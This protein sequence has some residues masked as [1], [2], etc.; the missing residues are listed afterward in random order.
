MRIWFV[1]VILLAVQGVYAFDLV[2][3]TADPSTPTSDGVLTGAYADFTAVF[4][5]E[6]D[7]DRVEFVFLTR[8]GPAVRAA[9]ICDDDS[10]TVGPV[11]L[12]L[13]GAEG[14]FIRTRAPSARSWFDDRIT[15]RVKTHG[16]QVS[17]LEVT[18]GPSSSIRFEAEDDSGSGSYRLVRDGVTIASDDVLSDTVELADPI[19]PGDEVR[20]ALV[21]TDAFGTVHTE[22]FGG[23]VPEEPPTI[24]S[25]SNR[26]YLDD[27]D[28]GLVGF[29]VSGSVEHVR[30]IVDGRE[31]PARC[32][33]GSCVAMI[34]RP[35]ASESV[36]VRV[37]DSF[38][39]TASRTATVSFVA[40]TVAPIFDR[41]TTR[42]ASYDGVTG[43]TDGEVFVDFIENAMMRPED[44][45]VS[46]DGRRTTARSCERVGSL[47]RCAVPMTGSGRIEFRSA[48]DAAGNDAT[49]PSEALTERRIE[50][51]SRAPRVLQLAVISGA[52]SSQADTVE[53][54]SAGDIVIAVQVVAEGSRASRA[55]VEVSD[56]SGTRIEELDL[57]CEMLAGSDARCTSDPL[58]ID[59]TSRLNIEI[60]DASGSPFRAQRL[61][62]V[63]GTS[64]PGVSRWSVIDVKEIPGYY[65]PG[66]LMPI[67][68][69]ARIG[70]PVLSGGMS[71]AGV[72]LVSCRGIE[73]GFASADGRTV[74]ITGFSDASAL[75]GGVGSCTVAVTTIR[76]GM[77]DPEPEEVDLE[78]RLAPIASAGI[79]DPASLYEKSGS[80]AKL[81]SALSW[82]ETAFGYAS[83]ACDAYE[84][85]NLVSLSVNLAAVATGGDVGATPMG[86]LLAQAGGALFRGVEGIGVVA[87]P[88]CAVANCQIPID[89]DGT[90]LQD[91]VLGVYED[92]EGGARSSI[93]DVFNDTLGYDVVGSASSVS[94]VEDSL[95]LSAITACV[96]GVI[97][98][99]R[100][101]TQATCARDLCLLRV[102]TGDYAGTAS[103]CS[104]SY[105]MQVCAFVGDEII[106]VV[107]WVSIFTDISDQIGGIIRQPL[108]IVADIGLEMLISAVTDLSPSAR[109][110]F[111]R[112]LAQIINLVNVG[113]SPSGPVSTTDYC[114]ELSDYLD[115][116]DERGVFE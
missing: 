39:S 110:D 115:D 71:I 93:N 97:S 74:V 98:N 1:V 105:A 82:A 90:T 84:G 9:N 23:R 65:L 42:Y 36:T 81:D 47:V 92:L 30:A 12:E 34:D 15:I 69:E 75:T 8:D 37:V 78:F 54:G 24:V 32:S 89:D 57:E 112:N 49:I 108:R 101:M 16:P 38:G 87:D 109:A 60:H 59:E 43:Y 86:V 27:T 83:L 3:L 102:H 85:I 5:S 61:V 14:L 88:L 70:S 96:P 11:P 33:S 53:I 35:A 17:S 72:S 99:M 46:I 2:S 25:I 79:E 41:F 20:F 91:V 95:V 64:V 52:G 19:E 44:V 103:M 68:I 31:Y 22:T 29:E 48:T 116:L 67:T 111:N 45:I 28:A 63:G 77:L 21:L 113:T 58:R 66:S 7:P 104:Y 106:S 4:D 80:A 55:R 18:T 76:G 73:G 50:S 6:P 100:E 51:D 10:C 13:M 94:R 114:E 62:E 40:D 26:A 107:P 56:S